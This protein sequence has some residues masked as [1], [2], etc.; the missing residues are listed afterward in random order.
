MY[1]VIG[2]D[3]CCVDW[4]GGCVWRML[5]FNWKRKSVLENES[6][7]KKRRT[8]RKRACVTFWAVANDGLGGLGL[9]KSCWRTRK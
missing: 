8:L 4:V 5:R 3:C 7:K 6:S 9:D 2:L 1:G